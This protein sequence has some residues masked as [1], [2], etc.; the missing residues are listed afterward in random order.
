MPIDNAFVFYKTESAKHRIADMREK[1]SNVDTDPRKAERF[2][3][4]E[5]PSCFYVFRRV[6]GTMTTESVCDLCGAAMSFASTAVDLLCKA[7]SAKHR[8]C[9]RCGADVE[10]VHRRKERVLESQV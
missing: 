10:L 3:A 6:G 7:C 2:A 5:C 8:L 9:C 4:R 1:L